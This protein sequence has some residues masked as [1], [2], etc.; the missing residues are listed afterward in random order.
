MDIEEAVEVEAQVVD[1]VE[2]AVE[3]DP[4]GGVEGSIPSNNSTVVKIVGAPHHKAGPQTIKAVLP[5]QTG[6]PPLRVE[7]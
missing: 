5:G 7:S 6:P 2:D 3:V 4:D 1:V